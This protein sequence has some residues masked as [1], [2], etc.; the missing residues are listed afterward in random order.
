MLKAPSPS[1][2]PQREKKRAS[3]PSELWD[4][5]YDELARKKLTKPGKQWCQEPPTIVAKVHEKGGELVLSGLP[6]AA[7]EQQ[8]AALGCSV[9]L[10]CF[11]AHPSDK[12]IKGKDEAGIHVPGTKLLNLHMGSLVDAEQQFSAISNEVCRALLKGD[13][14]L[15]HCMAGVH[16]AACA[17]ALLRAILHDETFETAAKEV[18]RVRATEIH[19]RVKSFGH[20]RLHR[21]VRCGKDL[22][23]APTPQPRPVGWA[24]ESQQDSRYAVM[25]AYV[26]VASEA[27]PLCMWRKK[28]F[29]TTPLRYGTARKAAERG[30][31]I[32]DRC[33]FDLP[34]SMRL[35]ATSARMEVN[36]LT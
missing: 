31:K 20:E 29:L 13:N 10:A 5:I 11:G 14:V 30:L 28:S 7:T 3:A 6:T 18:A 17:A 19:H 33:W 21:M 15:V 4:S 22:L 24:T 35:D 16:R 32:C 1:P 27:R 2:E 12:T 26:E 25:H 34:V 9:Q 8:F 36:A 23:G